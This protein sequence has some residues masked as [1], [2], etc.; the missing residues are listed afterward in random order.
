MGWECCARGSDSIVYT[1]IQCK[2]Q[3]DHGKLA[4]TANSPERGIHRS[5]VAGMDLALIAEQFVSCYNL[6]QVLAA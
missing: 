4:T 6:Y 2:Y 3:F 1:S 5:G